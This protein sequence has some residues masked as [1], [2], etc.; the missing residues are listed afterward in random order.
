MKITSIAALVL[1]TVL[2]AAWLAAAEPANPEL[3]RMRAA[4]RDTTAQLRSSQAELA[5]LQATQAAITDEK[6]TL[7][8]KYDA[9]KKQI[10]ADRTVTDKT[11]TTLNAE[12]A[13]QKAAAARLTEAWEK[14]KTTGAKA[15]EA[16]RAAE[17]EVARLKAEAIVR[18]RRSA[19]LQAK[20]LALYLTGNE[21][22]TRYEEFSF[23]N[24]LKAKEPFVGL[25][26]TKL[27]NLVQ[28]YQDK[29]LDQRA[30]P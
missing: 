10:V 13:E 23:G 30:K 15:A 22:L 4:L 2:P 27:E 20:N 12:L 18:D 25:S 7:A 29:L 28:D 1:C 24:A 8:E 14:S 6:K 19:D 16:A 9:L 5:G 21:I 3:D 11:V 17:T 26:R